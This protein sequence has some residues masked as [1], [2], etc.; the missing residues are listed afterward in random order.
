[1]QT[2]GVVIALV[3]WVVWWLFL[4][5]WNVAGKTLKGGGWVGLMLL[6]LLAVLIWG[7]LSP[8]DREVLP[9]PLPNFVEEFTI[10]FGLYVVMLGCGALQMAL[11]PPRE[12]T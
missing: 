3:L 9:M 12:S 5:D 8:A 4:V 11:W 1:M 10:V 2:A 6:G 7:S